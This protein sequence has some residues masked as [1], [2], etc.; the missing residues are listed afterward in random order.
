M[1][2]SLQINDFALFEN[3]QVSFQPGLNV[4]TGESGAGK[5]LVL[6][7]LCS[8]FGGRDSIANIRNGKEKF[9]IQA[10]FDLSKNL[11]AKDWLREK[12]FS[13]TDQISLSKEVSKDGKSKLLLGESLVSLQLVKEFGTFVSE[14]QTQHEQVHLLEKENQ[15]EFLDRFCGLEIQRKAFQ[16]D[17]LKYQ[18][19]KKQL[20]E[21]NL[22]LKERNERKEF[23]LFQLQ[24]IEEAKLKEG[25][26]EELVREEKLLSQGEKLSSYFQEALKVLEDDSSGILTNL[27]EL[28]HLLE[29]MDSIQETQN[30]FYQTIVSQLETLKD[31]SFQLN[32][33]AEE[34]FFSPQRLDNIQSRL[35]LFQ[36]L[37]KKY[38]NTSSS[39]EEIY[40]EKKL[41]LERLE[42][43]EFYFEEVEKEFV[44]VLESVKS[45]AL[46][47]S[48]I[49]RNALDEFEKAIQKEFKDLG[50]ASAK[51][52]IVLRWEESAE[53]EWKNGEKSYVLRPNGLDLAELYF[54]AN[55]GEKP[56]PLRKVASG[57]EL[58]R[59]LLAL[60]S[61]V[62]KKSI[63][64]KILVFDEIDQGLGGE[65]S[66]VLGEK[67][68]TISGEH[69]ILLITHTHEVAARAQNHCKVEKQVVGNRTVS[70]VTPILP[71]ERHL[72]LA[73]MIAGEKPT[74]GAILHAR[75]LL[76]RKVS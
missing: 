58:S 62:G 15:L 11:P 10:K 76:E 59:I 8:L 44:G 50:L 18:N 66:K 13:N 34:L 20:G 6:D 47:L 23:L 53:G 69:Q 57:G 51:I 67:L 52:Q 4:L 73:R 55:L 35:N 14:I 48:K 32:R 64:S 19:L 38:G 25:E 1:I 36:K 46:E 2:Q 12:G 26:E 9:S 74:E 49:R 30:P 22:Q 56:R 37:K 40:Q 65:T 61:I 41:E 27:R 54:S 43:T 75:S 28:V 39:I 29:K 17:F 21:L 70:T 33:D 71:K 60:R 68:K 31:L 16:K 42:K 72:E 7:A 5:S 24:E 3:V 45:K 63:G